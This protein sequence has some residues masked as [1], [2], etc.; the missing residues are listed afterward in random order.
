M[1]LKI[2]KKLYRKIY[3]FVKEC[4]S[5]GGGSIYLSMSLSQMSLLSFFRLF[6]QVEIISIL[7]H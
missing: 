6:H 7:K 2:T 1:I 4:K 3:F 5:M